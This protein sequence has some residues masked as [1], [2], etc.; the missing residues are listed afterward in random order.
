MIENLKYRDE[1]KLGR[2]EGEEK[3]QQRIALNLLKMNH[4]IPVIKQATS[5]SEAEI[6]ALKEELKH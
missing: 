5:L 4:P 6:L 1:R 2:I 3:T